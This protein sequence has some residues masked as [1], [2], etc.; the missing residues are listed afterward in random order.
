VNESRPEP[1]PENFD[2][3]VEGEPEPLPLPEPDD[4]TCLLC[5][6]AKGTNPKFCGTC[7]R[8]IDEELEGVVNVINL[9]GEDWRRLECSIRRAGARA[10]RLV[11]LRINGRG[12]EL[13]VTLA[14]DLP[15]AVGRVRGGEYWS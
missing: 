6:R 8:V 7:Q 11:G 10:F 4:V 12:E 13:V 3:W 1:E 2:A 15:N 5:Q 14:A 9:S